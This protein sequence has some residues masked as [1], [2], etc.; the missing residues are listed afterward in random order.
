MS[1]WEIAIFLPTEQFKKKGKVA[2][3]A[4]SAKIARRT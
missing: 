1:D 2:V 4:E 3:W